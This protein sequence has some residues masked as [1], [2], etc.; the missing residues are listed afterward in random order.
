MKLAFRAAKPL[1][2]EGLVEPVG[3]IRRFTEKEHRRDASLDE[4]TRYIAQEKS[5]NAL[6]MKTL[7]HVNLVQFAHKSRHTT[8][9]ARALRKAD[10]LTGAILDDK[11]KPASVRNRKRLPPLALSEFIRRAATA[12]APMCFVER[13]HVQS[14]QRG[15]VGFMCISDV[16]CHT[17]YGCE[18]PI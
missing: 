17:A 11:G 9:V 8:I 13:L 1:C 16:E 4:P 18:Y 6:P 2:A 15:H 7:Q 5:A 12:S 3:W 14:R 10:E